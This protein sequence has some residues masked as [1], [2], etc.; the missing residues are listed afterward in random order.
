ML[1]TEKP[2]DFKPKIDVVS[3]YVENNG[4]ILLLHRCGSKS[5]GNKWGPPA[6]KVSDGESLVHAMVREINEETGLIVTPAEL[7]YSNL[8]YLRYP[9]FDYHYHTYCLKVESCLE[10]C[11]SCDEHDDY[12]W[13]G[14]MEALKLPL[15]DGEDESIKET[16]NV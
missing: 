5:Q 6:G 15:V 10:I 2:E 7:T 3:C 1:F 12:R 16:F 4:K 14:P 13:I 11:L 9:S 8:F